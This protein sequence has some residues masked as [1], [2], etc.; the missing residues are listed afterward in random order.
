MIFWYNISL[1]IFKLT[2]NIC[3][4][5][6]AEL[7]ILLCI[8]GLKASEQKSYQFLKKELPVRL[9]NI[10]K[11]IHLLPDNLLKM[12]SVNLVNNWYAQSFNEMIEFEVD[13]GFT[14]QTLTK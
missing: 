10:M 12:P 1:Y 9:A 13:D 7:I 14:E 8:T 5:T 4:Y 3:K 6:I 11:E 2:Y